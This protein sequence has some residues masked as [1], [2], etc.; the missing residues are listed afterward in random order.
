[1]DSSGQATEHSF[2]QPQPYP[3]ASDFLDYSMPPLVDRPYTPSSALPYPAAHTAP[4][5]TS[6][7][8]RLSINT[9]AFLGCGGLSASDAY[10]PLTPASAGPLSACAS[11][12]SALGGGS[13]P[14]TPVDGC[15][16][17]SRPGSSHGAW[18]WGRPRSADEPALAAPLARAPVVLSAIGEQEVSHHMTM[19]GGMVYSP[20]EA[21]YPQQT[22]ASGEAQMYDAYPSA[23]QQVAQYGAPFDAA[24]YAIPASYGMPPADGCTGCTPPIQFAFTVPDHGPA[25]C[26]DNLDD[27]PFVFQPP[28]YSF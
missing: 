17:A 7:P 10:S 5:Q 8:P 21:M 14:G 15:W 22:S 20:I 18:A 19:G 26:S 28:A 2:A 11:L 1:M 12:P 25:P 24:G 6:G 27:T 9:L 23:Q 13:M 4:P 3:N 16:D